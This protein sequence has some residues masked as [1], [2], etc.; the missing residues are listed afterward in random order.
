M[1]NTEIAATLRERREHYEAARADAAKEVEDWQARAAE[2][3][4]RI[5]EIDFALEQLDAPS[6]HAMN[7]PRMDP[8]QKAKRGDVQVEVLGFLAN[9]RSEH[10][11]DERTIAEALGRKASQIL[12][13]CH[14]LLKARKIVNEER[15]FALPRPVPLDNAAA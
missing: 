7:D 4:T 15:G 11:P 6:P 3:D 10:A 5:E 2:Y 14:S 12:K 9:N 1:D 8:P 13:V